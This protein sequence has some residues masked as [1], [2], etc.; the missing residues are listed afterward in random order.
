MPDGHRRAWPILGTR[1]DREHAIRIGVRRKEDLLDE[2]SAARRTVSG[3][4]AA[5]ASPAA[6]RRSSKGSDLMS[7]ACERQV[8]TPSCQ[9]SYTLLLVGRLLARRGVATLLPRAEPWLWV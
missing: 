3:D 7:R 6:M 1:A 9:L 8:S 5:S 2:K 4:H